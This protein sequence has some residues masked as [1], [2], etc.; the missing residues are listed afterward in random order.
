M[1]EYAHS[2]F[3]EELKEPEIPNP[4]DRSQ[5]CTPEPDSIPDEQRPDIARIIDSEH[6]VGLSLKE[7]NDIETFEKFNTNFDPEPARKKYGPELIA[8]MPKWLEAQR[9]DKTN[10]IKR[11][12]AQIDLSKASPD[13]G[14]VLE[15]VQHAIQNPSEKLRLAIYGTAGTGKSWTI[16]AITQL[17]R[18][19][20]LKYHLA[21]T[22]GV[23][24]LNIGGVT[25]HSLLKLPVQGKK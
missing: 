12:H 15:I 16:H 7:N 5:A 8:L 23:A 3:L 9:K 11:V 24:A 1:T 19:A 2:L 10:K 18:E 17:L 4:E 20:N 13:Q 25:L 21:G 6:V 22:S 14:R